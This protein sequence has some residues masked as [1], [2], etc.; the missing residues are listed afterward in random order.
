MHSRVAFNTL[1]RQFFVTYNSSEDSTVASP[2]IK[3]VIVDEAGSPV[4]DELII[5]NVPGD[6]Y[7]PY[8]VYNPTDDTYLVNWEDFRQRPHLGAEWRHLRCAA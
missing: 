3:G 5:N 7:N 6:E 4:G 1:K 8:I 2:D